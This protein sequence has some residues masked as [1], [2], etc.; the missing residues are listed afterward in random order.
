MQD[1]ITG[2]FLLLENA[3]Q[4]GDFVTVAGLSGSV[5]NL[6]IRTMRLRA[7]DGSVHI[8]PF[9][10]VTSV[11]NANRGIGNAAISVSVAYHEDTDRV[12]QAL[13]Q[14]AAEMRQEAKFKSAMLGELQLWGVDKVDGASATL[15]GQIV[16]TDS[17]RWEVQR[18]FN[19]RMKQKFQELG[20]VIAMPNASMLLQAPTARSTNPKEGSDASRLDHDDMQERPAPKLAQSR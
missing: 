13:K 7:G 16:C 6:S 9:S 8:V 2:L 20:I 1:L 19:R 5:E 18:E 4:V 15:V 11:T 12:G 14:I 10:S 17:G 3:I